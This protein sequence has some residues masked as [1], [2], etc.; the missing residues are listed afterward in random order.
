MV[1][2]FTMSALIL[3]FPIC[4]LEGK[5]LVSKHLDLMLRLQSLRT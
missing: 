5:G 2:A 3:C 1:K 4:G